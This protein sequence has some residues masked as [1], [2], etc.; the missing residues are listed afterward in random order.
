MIYLSSL[1]FKHVLTNFARLEIESKMFKL[2]I[3][4]VQLRDLNFVL[5]SDIFVNF[6]GQLQASHLILGCNPVYTS[7]QPFG[8]ALL[9][10]NPL[11]SYI[12]IRH[13]NFLPP[14]LTVGE[15]Q[16]LGP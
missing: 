16:D 2:D 9:V 4:V 3:M 14:N 12:D 5:W 10:D 7:Y 6:D 13:P 1:L 15:A 11:L 8:Q